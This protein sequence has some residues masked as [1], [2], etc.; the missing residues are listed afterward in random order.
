MTGSLE[1]IDPDSW[2][3]GFSFGAVLAGITSTLLY[4][5]LL[6]RAAYALGSFLVGFMWRITWMAAGLILFFAGVLFTAD[7]SLQNQSDHL[8]IFSCVV[9]MSLGVLFIWSAFTR[10][11][12]QFRAEMKQIQS[13]AT[14]MEELTENL[15]ALSLEVSAIS[16]KLSSDMRLKDPLDG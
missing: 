5:A 13:R 8:T 16:A 1:Q 3:V 9:A 2:W 15:N 10:T 6:K 7:C 4:E 14:K 11:R 12:A